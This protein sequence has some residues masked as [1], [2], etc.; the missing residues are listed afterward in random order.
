MKSKRAIAYWILTVLFVLPML[1]GGVADLILAE[2]VREALTH[3]G[4]PL[5]LGR[6]L[7]VLKILGVI[8]VLAPGFRLLKEW[9]YAGFAFDLLGA[10]VSH[11]AVGDPLGDV[12]PPLVIA[13][14][15]AGSYLL[16]PASRRLPQAP[17][18]G[19]EPTAPPEA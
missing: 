8:A 17:V 15:G 13:L 14:I 10:L 3:L 16:R 19:S 7:G 18:L 12:A 5:Y 6:L 4:Y 9:A 11:V 1:G 2:P